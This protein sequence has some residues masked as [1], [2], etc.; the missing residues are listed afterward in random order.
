V[1]DG[2]KPAG[3]EGYKTILRDVLD[4]R[5]SGVRQRLATALGTNRSFISQI[6]NPA[7]PVPIPVQ[8]VA[9]ILE[10]CHPS[11]AERDAFLAAYEHAHPGRIDAKTQGLRWRPVTVQVPDLVDEAKNRVIDAMVTD[12][13]ARLARFVEDL[14]TPPR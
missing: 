5:P 1:S 14:Q 7:Y 13:A 6:T 11:P 12:F 2:A 4:R 9:T 3:V 10:I 8:H